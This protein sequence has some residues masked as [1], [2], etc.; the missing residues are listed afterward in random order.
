VTLGS[1]SRDEQRN[2]PGEPSWGFVID[3]GDED[4]GGSLVVED[5]VKTAKEIYSE[6][7]SAM[8]RISLKGNTTHDGIAIKAFCMIAENKRKLYHQ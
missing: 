8:R 1:L 3:C 4:I 2:R 7:I 5:I 6:Q